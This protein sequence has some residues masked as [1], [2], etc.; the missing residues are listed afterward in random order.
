MFYVPNTLNNFSKLQR[1]KYT[2][3]SLTEWVAIVITLV[4]LH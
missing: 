1:L 4:D 2:L 3:I